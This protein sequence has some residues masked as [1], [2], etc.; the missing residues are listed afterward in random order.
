MYINDL[1]HKSISYFWSVVDRFKFLLILLATPK[2]RADCFKQQGSYVIIQAKHRSPDLLSDLSP[3]L[4]GMNAGMVYTIG[5]S[6][7]QQISTWWQ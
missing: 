5:P 1:P 3:L 2:K 4:C 7:Y 6:D